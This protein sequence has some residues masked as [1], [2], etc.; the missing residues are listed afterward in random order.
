MPT[1]R[2]QP[3]NWRSRSDG[4]HYWTEM[5]IQWVPKEA[6]IATITATVGMGLIYYL[7]PRVHWTALILSWLVLA[8]LVY[9]TG[10]ELSARTAKRLQRRESDP[11]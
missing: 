7:E 1:R 6:I 9:Q 11:S 2:L 5:K 10:C 8:S 3:I 4:A